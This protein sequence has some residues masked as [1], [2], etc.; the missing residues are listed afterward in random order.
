MNILKMRYFDKLDRDVS[1]SAALNI[2][3]GVLSV[4]AVV[5]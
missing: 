3:N 1:Y 2:S 5:I 4:P